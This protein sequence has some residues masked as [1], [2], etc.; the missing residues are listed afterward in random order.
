MQTWSQ[1]RWLTSDG[2]QLR[3]ASES[4]EEM[5]DEEYDEAW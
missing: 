5:L 2:E 1:I 4:V 3:V